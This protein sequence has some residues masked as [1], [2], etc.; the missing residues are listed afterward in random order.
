MACWPGKPREELRALQQEALDVEKQY[1]EELRSETPPHPTEIPG[2]HGVE[3]RALLGRAELRNYV[4]A[5]VEN[6]AVG[7]AE[8]EL[9][10][11]LETRTAQNGGVML[12]WE[13]LDPGPAEARAAI[14]QRADTATTLAATSGIGT[15]QDQIIQRVFAQTAAAFL[16]VRMVGVGVG[17]HSYPIITAGQT[18]DLKTAGTAHDATAAT[19]S[20]SVLEPKRL[21]ARYVI[22]VEDIAKLAGYEEALRMDLNGAMGE[23]LDHFV[24]NGDDATDPQWSGFFDALTDPTAPSDVAT[25]ADFLKA[26]GGG[27]DGRY[28]TSLAQVR[29]LVGDET[30]GHAAAVTN[31]GS[32][33]TAVQYAMGA[34][35]GL[36]ASALVPDAASNIQQAILAK[37]GPGWMDNSVCNTWPGVEMIRDPYSGA[38]KG[39]VALTAISLVDFALI[40]KAGFAQLAFKLA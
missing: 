24:L 35:G 30:Y 19:I 29:L 20:A 37:T 23:R 40:R 16:G 22:R 15:V 12:P 4:A 14:E 36:Q 6:R 28:A 5:A 26:Y 27:V 11:A 10:S 32:G 31:T 7:G 1:Q 34:T 9:Q 8:A 18:P 39:E 38:S 21:T 25:Y 13:M 3:V 2:G 17:Q 33:A